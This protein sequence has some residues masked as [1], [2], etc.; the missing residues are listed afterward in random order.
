[1]A[2]INKNNGD[3]N[4][5][6][7]NKVEI[8]D[9][10]NVLSISQAFDHEI[11]ENNIT[12]KGGSSWDN[13]YGTP[14][15]IILDIKQNET[16]AGPLWNI[17]LK[18]RYPKDQASI[19]NQFYKMVNKPKI[20]KIT[21]NNSLK[22]LLGSIESPM[23]MNFNI[24]KPGQVSEYNGY[25]IQFTGSLTHPPYYLTTTTEQSDSGS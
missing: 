17:I 11:E 16:D 4:A 24:K 8:I 1:M 23:M 18:L 3:Q 2:D 10:F 5:G 12:L 22:M 21:D 20:I 14:D 7:N 25:E 6:G 9:Y 19:T 13:F 15:T